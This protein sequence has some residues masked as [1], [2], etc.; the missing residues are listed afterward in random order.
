MGKTLEGVLLTGAAIVKSSGS[1][2]GSA[3]LEL[4]A[5]A[6]SLQG[7]VICPDVLNGAEVS[8]FTAT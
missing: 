5:S 4:T 1:Y 6:G 2:D 8:K 3:F 7:T